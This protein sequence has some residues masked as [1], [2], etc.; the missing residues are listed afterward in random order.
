MKFCTDLSHHAWT[1]EPDPER[2][3][4]AT[5]SAIRVADAAGLDAV[6]LS[7]DPDSWDAFAVLGAAARQTERIRLGTGVTNPYLRHPNLLAMSAATLDRLSGGRAFL[8]LGRGQP[9]WYERA[10]GIPVGHPASVLSEGIDLVRQWWRPPYVASSSGY[11]KINE[12]HRAIGPVQ[13]HLPIYV[14]ALGRQGLRVA[15]EKSDGLLISDF[16]SEAW[17]ARIIPQIRQQVADRG[18]DPDSY[19]FFLRSAVEVTD[20]L[21][22]A[23]NRRKNMMAI[24]HTLPGMAQHMEVPGFDVPAIIARVREVMRTDEML[25][26][27]GAFIDIRRVADFAAARR[28]IPDE[29]ILALSFIGTADEVRARL[30][31]YADLGITHAFLRP[32]ETADPEEYAALVASVTP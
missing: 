4:E 24:V 5:L 28:L 1:R 7:E 18:G 32:P 22:A 8:G 9:E 3:V 19:S 6:W 27:G 23:I 2:A 29:L 21:E 20:D 17:L 13:S 15:A 12:W 11:F 10:L 26:R 25:A 16:A 31:R 30:R 14:A